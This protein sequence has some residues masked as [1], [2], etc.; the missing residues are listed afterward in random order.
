MSKSHSTSD[1]EACKRKYEAAMR[2]KRAHEKVHG[3]I[4][5]RSTAPQDLAHLLARAT[6][7]IFVD[8]QRDW[9]DGNGVCLQDIRSNVETMLRDEF[10]LLR[11]RTRALYQYTG[12]ST[13]EPAVRS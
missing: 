1:D 7:C 6:M 4:R 11:E 9:L 3:P 10:N 5:P 8:A 13:D 12:E 2:E